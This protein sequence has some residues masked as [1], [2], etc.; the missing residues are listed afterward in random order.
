MAIAYSTEDESPALGPG[1]VYLNPGP[2]R[3]PAAGPAPI[4]FSGGTGCQPTVHRLVPRPIQ[5]AHSRF[6]GPF[7]R[8][9]L[10]GDL[11]G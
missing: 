2:A 10:P 4:V 3:S 7:Q 11:L 9:C 8:T 5:S 1:L 6:G